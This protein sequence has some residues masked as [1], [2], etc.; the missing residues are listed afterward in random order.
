M[1]VNICY[2]PITIII[3]ICF[4]HHNWSINFGWSTKSHFAWKIKQDFCQ[5]GK[6]LFLKVRLGPKITSLYFEGEHS[7][8]RIPSSHWSPGNLWTGRW[9]KKQNVDSPTSPLPTPSPGLSPDYA[10]WQCVRSPWPTYYCILFVYS[11]N[12][13]IISITVYST[14]HIAILLVWETLAT[15]CQNPISW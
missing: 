10:K 9:P 15:K 1:F 5:L 14:I 7:K 2:I 3:N 11:S 12:Y 8:G 13:H 4:V 6:I